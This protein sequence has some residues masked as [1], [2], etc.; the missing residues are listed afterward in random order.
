[1]KANIIFSSI[2]MLIFVSSI[3]YAYDL[4][5]FPKPFVKNAVF[6]VSLVV[7]DNAKAR[8]VIGITDIGMSLQFD[9]QKKKTLN[10]EGVD[11]EVNELIRVDAGATKLASALQGKE[12]E[13]NLI[14]VGGACANSVVAFL[15]GFPE[16]CTEGFEYGKGK[17]QLMEHDNGKYA[18]I[19]AGLTEE[20][21]R[22][23]A[24]VLANYRDYEAE[25]K[26]NIVVVADTALS[27]P[28]LRRIS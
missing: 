15:Y 14:L 11:Y 5:D 7:G 28:S 24:R 4:S 13:E 18:L 21:T 23:A 9:M 22:A 19:V 26:G 3:V 2:V 20:D 8:D 6:D 27:K 10:K 12:K 17:I 1:M 16:D 25:F